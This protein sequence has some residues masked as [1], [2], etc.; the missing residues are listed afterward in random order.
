MGFAMHLCRITEMSESSKS[1]HQLQLLGSEGNQYTPGESH[2]C[3][4]LLAYGLPW[5]LL[6]N[7]ERGVGGHKTVVVALQDLEMDL[8]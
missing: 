1:H 8:T 6:Q 7:H 3:N 4:L 2:L 5:M